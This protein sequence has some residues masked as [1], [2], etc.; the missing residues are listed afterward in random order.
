MRLELAEVSSFSFFFSSFILFDA[1]SSFHRHRSS[2]FFFFKG[3]VTMNENKEKEIANGEDITLPKETT[4]VE[5]RP[6]R[7]GLKPLLPSSSGK[8]KVD[9]VIDKSTPPSHR[10]LKK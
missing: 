4:P 8:R 3:M 5:T 9:K 2:H 7:T 10:N 6:A 1:E